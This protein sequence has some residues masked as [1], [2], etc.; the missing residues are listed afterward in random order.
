[1]RPAPSGS[2]WHTRWG[3]PSPADHRAASWIRHEH[4]TAFQLPRL[5][6]CTCRDCGGTGERHDG[7]HRMA[8]L[9]G[10]HHGHIPSADTVQRAKRAVRDGAW[11]D[12]HRYFVDALADLLEVD[13]A[14]LADRTTLERPA[15]LPVFAGLVVTA[16]WLA[17]DEQRFAYRRTDES[18]AQWWE[19]SK[20]QARAALTALR[21]D[22]WSPKSTTW[23]ELFPR[24]PTPRQF[25]NAAMAAAPAAGAGAGHRR[26][27]HRI[28]KDRARPLVRA[29]P[30]PYQRLPRLLHGDALARRHGPGRRRAH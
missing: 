26:S 24:T 21:L 4:I 3:S 11:D 18:A 16:D 1:M 10:G 30:R 9:L 5:L 28:G 6:G 13:L 8:L 2:D 14:L 29:P 15:T 25:Q 12:L 20:K 19:Q 7:L 22:A 23:A 27:R 17:S